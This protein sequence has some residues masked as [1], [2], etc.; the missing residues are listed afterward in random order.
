MIDAIRNA[1]RDHGGIDDYRITE[2]VKSGVEWYLVG[3]SLD[4][5]RSTDTR[6]YTLT[7]YVDSMDSGVVK[8]RG[9]YST[10][11]HPTASGD[12]VRAAVARAAR[13][14]A[15]SSPSTWTASAAGTTAQM[16]AIPSGS[17]RG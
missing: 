12:E 3:R 16:P 9:A 5:A 4:T 13:A 2:T 17:G 6:N 15:S 1:V 10:T 7:V 14:V 8:T 11:I